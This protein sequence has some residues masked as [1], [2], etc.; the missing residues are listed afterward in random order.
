MSSPSEM[1]AERILKR[2]VQEKLLSEHEAKK[3]LSKLADGKLRSEDWHLAI[4]LSTPR[5]TKP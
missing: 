1:L 4:E 3:L 2:L 5:K